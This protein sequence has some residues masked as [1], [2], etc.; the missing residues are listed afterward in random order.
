MTAGAGAGRVARQAGAY[1]PFILRLA[2]PEALRV[3]LCVAHVRRDVREVRRVA[4]QIARA[5]DVAAPGTG[6][7]AE[8]GSA[9]A[10]SPATVRPAR[11]TG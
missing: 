7:A 6:V 8:M 3:V 5:H 11:L 2:G 1:P 10:P 4:A 9:T